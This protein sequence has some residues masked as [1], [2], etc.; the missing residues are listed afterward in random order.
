[1][2]NIQEEIWKDIPSFEGLYQV[3]N[4]GNVKSLSRVV[5]K[6]CF[7]SVTIKEKIL[8]QEKTKIGYIRV[9]LSKD[10]VTTRFLLHRLVMHVF[11]HASTLQ[12]DHKDEDKENNSFS[13]LRYVTGM[14]NKTFYHEKRKDKT[15][16]KF[17]G[18]Y[19]NKTHKR[20]MSAIS[21]NGER[22]RLGYFKNE[23]DAHNAY[24]EVKKQYC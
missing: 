20:W 9:S 17:I 10:S 16:S 13:N 21:I 1:M 3:S 15:T 7:K 23:I 5:Y 8:R 6:G 18:V 14:Q 19:W 2:T 24:Q 4:L 12:V 22:K 11:L